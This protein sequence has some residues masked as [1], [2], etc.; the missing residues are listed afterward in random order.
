MLSGYRALYSADR[1][2]FFRSKVMGELGAD[3]IKVERPGVTPGGHGAPFYKDTT[4]STNSLSV[5]Y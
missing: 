5:A 2:G 1:K 3:V 4:D